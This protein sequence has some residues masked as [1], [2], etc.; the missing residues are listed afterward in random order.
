MKIILALF[1]AS[2]FPA[3]AH[4]QKWS[5]DPLTDQM[6]TF[7]ATIIREKLFLS[8]CKNHAQ[9]KQCDGIND[10][11]ETKYMAYEAAMKLGQEQIEEDKKQAAIRAEKAKPVSLG[12]A[13]R[14]QLVIAQAAHQQRL[15][16]AEKKDK[17]CVSDCPLPLN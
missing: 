9:E 12:E 16:E 3:L 15:K 17:K 4:A 8:W 11:I 5:D 14:K 1:V 7:E 13:A 10:H 6:K 2:L